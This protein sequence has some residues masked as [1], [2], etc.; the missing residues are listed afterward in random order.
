MEVQ[1][2]AENLSD[3]YVYAMRVVRSMLSRPEVF[4]SSEIK[5][6]KS[7]AWLIK[8]DIN[9]YVLRGLP[10]ESKPYWQSLQKEM[11]KILDGIEV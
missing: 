7:L 10:V 5:D 3:E 2:N 9:M 8:L 1:V 6:A 11:K 4:T